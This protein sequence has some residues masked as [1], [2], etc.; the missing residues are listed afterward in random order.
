MS[1]AMITMALILTLHLMS[2]GNP[3]AAFTLRFGPAPVAD[4]SASFRGTADADIPTPRMLN[5]IV[6]ADGVT[7][8]PVQ[9]V[10]ETIPIEPEIRV[11]RQTQPRTA[12]V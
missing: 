9:T 1:R 12:N 11:R 7:F 10:P 4:D 8:G 6:R 5:V 3:A 2:G